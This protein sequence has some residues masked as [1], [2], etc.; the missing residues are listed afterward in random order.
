MRRHFDARTQRTR[1]TW[2]FRR[3]GTIERRRLSIRLYN[4]TEIRALLREAGFRDIRFFGHPLVGRFTRHSPR[5]IAIGKR[6]SLSDVT[7]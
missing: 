3:G 4:G 2:T 6:P 5:F 1:A 7:R